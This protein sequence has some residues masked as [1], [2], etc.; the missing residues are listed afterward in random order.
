MIKKRLAL[1][2]L[3]LLLACGAAH[4]ESG[5]LGQQVLAETNAAR[6]NPQRYAEYIREFRKSF[7]GKAYRLPGT[8]N[9][10][11]TSE[12]KGALDEAVR[13]LSRQRPLPALS[14]SPG[15]AMA[16][17]DLVREQAA[18]GETGHGERGDTKKRI[19]EYGSW[20]SS[21]GENISYGP[22]TARQ[23]VMGLIIDD[24]VADRGHRKNIFDRSFTTAGA[25]CGPHPLYRTI[26]VT[27]FAGGFQGR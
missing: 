8:L 16:A 13:F 9:M 23:V 26:C 24:G 2:C 1:S 20:R 18:S 3:L 17:A 21:L 22:E 12:G 6:Q 10:V 19:E 27:D 7:I 14:W 4:G 25:A 15:L 5:G 11:M